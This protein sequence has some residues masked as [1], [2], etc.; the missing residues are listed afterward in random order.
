MQRFFSLVLLLFLVLPSSP[1]NHPGCLLTGLGAL[2][3][4][5]LLIFQNTILSLVA[6]IQIVANDLI[7]EGD[8]IEVPSLWG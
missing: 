7:K 6:S 1:V 5:L 3:A 2:T 4:V 8:W